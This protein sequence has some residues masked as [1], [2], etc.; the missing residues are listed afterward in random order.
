[1]IL[2]EHEDVSS[3]PLSV[4]HGQID[5]LIHLFWPGKTTITTT[6][7]I[8]DDGERCNRLAFKNHR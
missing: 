7:H 3:V 2:R 5:G 8:M 6:T 1:M 4:K